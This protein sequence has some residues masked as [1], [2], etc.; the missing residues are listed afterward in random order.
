MRKR[1]QDLYDR[2]LYLQAHAVA[3]EHAPLREWQGVR[4][5][6]LA[7]RLAANLGSRKL[8]RVLESL[9][10]RE[11]PKD[12]QAIY[13]GAHALLDR[14]G[15]LAAWKFADEHK[16]LEEAPA[17]IR[18]DGYAFRA[19]IASRLHDFDEA[20][21]LL[22]R[23]EEI[24]A[25]QAR[26]ETRK[27]PARPPPPPPPPPPPSPGSPRGIGGVGGLKDGLEGLEEKVIR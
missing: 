25:V 17:T 7:G 26:L 12:P 6:I 21:R 23:A 2:G 3:L 18:A 15:I 16:V 8:S 20:Y 27:E 11:D 19:G 10:L 24:A 5:R 9:A 4:D 13:Y 22:G 14:C 1:A